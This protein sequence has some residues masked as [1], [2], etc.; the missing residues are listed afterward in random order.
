MNH[1]TQKHRKEV[2]KKLILQTFGLFVNLATIFWVAYAFF[3]GI[4]HLVPVLIIVLW[5][6]ISGKYI[7]VGN[8]PVYLA[9][10][11]V[12]FYSAYML[13]G[14]HALS[15]PVLYSAFIYVA[16]GI[17]ASQLVRLEKDV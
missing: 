11:L 3:Q 9:Y 6:A 4:E 12:S 13:G 10:M 15:C 1:L 8:W 2:R 7:G 14:L 5:M 17:T 16:F